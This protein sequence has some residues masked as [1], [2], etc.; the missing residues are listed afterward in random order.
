MAALTSVR[1]SKFL[2]QRLDITF[3]N[4]SFYTD[5][6]VTYYWATS[7]TTG[8]WKTFVANRVKEIQAGS[9]PEDWYFSPGEHNVARDL[10][11]NRSRLRFRLNERRW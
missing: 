8:K 7:A 4:I 6:L 2:T 1:L 9:N 5:S 10:R 3:A 11:P